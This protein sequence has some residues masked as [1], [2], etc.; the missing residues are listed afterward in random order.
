MAS[1][2]IQPVGPIGSNEQIRPFLST[3]TWI[4]SLPIKR[5][6]TTL[7]GS[8]LGIAS[9]VTIS[10]T[11][12]FGGSTHGRQGPSLAL[13]PDNESELDARW[14]GAISRDLDSPRLSSTPWR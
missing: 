10:Q 12:C 13:G 3:A 14:R 7:F 4:D 1:E 6:R 9:D 8:L 5:L 2:A 11:I